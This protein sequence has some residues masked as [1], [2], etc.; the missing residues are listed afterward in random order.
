MISQHPYHI[1]P[2]TPSSL[3]LIDFGTSYKYMST[4]V[5]GQ[6]SHNPNITGQKFYLNTLFASKHTIMGNQSSRR[7]DIIQ[8]V[9]N[10][11]YL[12]NPKDS[13]MYRFQDAQDPVAVMRDFKVNALPKEICEGDRCG[14]ITDLCA[15]AYSYKYDEMPRYGVLKFILENELIKLN[16]VPDQIYSFLQP[17]NTFIG[18]ICV[19]ENRNMS[20][21]SMGSQMDNTS[22]RNNS[23]SG[24]KLD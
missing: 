10:L 14:C 9:Y 11:I 21:E 13:W 8:I 19:Q 1:L 24:V 2:W 15:E 23:D 16:V 3:F 12:L 18:R 20:P 17:T 4:N 22:E 6:E 5:M 7:D